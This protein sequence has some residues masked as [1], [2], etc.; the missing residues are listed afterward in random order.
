MALKVCD[1]KSFDN[2]VVWRELRYSLYFPIKRGAKELLRVVEFSNH[3]ILVRCVAECKGTSISET[4]SCRLGARV[5]HWQH[6]DLPLWILWVETP[7]LIDH[8]KSK[9]YLSAALGGDGLAT[10]IFFDMMG[11]QTICRA[12]KTEYLCVRQIIFPQAWERPNITPVVKQGVLIYYDL[13][14]QFAAK[15]E[16]SQHHTTPRIHN[17]SGCHSNKIPILYTNKHITPILIPFPVAIP[18]LGSE[19]PRWRIWV[20]PG[21]WRFDDTGG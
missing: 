15:L 1:W 8:G 14:I 20:A 21:P 2:P 12:A 4:N 3:L 7:S 5:R 11:A 13:L 18:R 9:V 6:L 16:I 10:Q 17:T 19:R